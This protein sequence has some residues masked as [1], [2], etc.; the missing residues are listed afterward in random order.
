MSVQQ[1]IL[2]G[3]DGTAKTAAYRPD[4]RIQEALFATNTCLQQLE[5]S[6]APL[7]DSL[8]D[9]HLVFVAYVP[10]SGSTLLT[11]LLARTSQW[12]YVSN[13]QSRFWL[14][15]YVGGLLEQSIAPR[16]YD[17][18]PLESDF[19]LTPNC[20][21]PA[22]FSYFWERWLR[23]TPELDHQ[24][25]PERWQ[26]CDELGLRRELRLIGSLHPGPLLFKKEWLG[27]NACYLLDAFPS[28]KLLH[29]VRDPVDVARSILGA[30]RQVFGHRDCWWG[31]KPASWDRLRSLTWH[32]QIAG[33]IHAILELTNEAADRFPSRCLTLSYET[34][35]AQP[36]TTL[37]QVH[38]WAGLEVSQ[39][40]NIPDQLPHRTRSSV[41]SESQ[42]DAEL[43][44]LMEALLRLNIRPERSTP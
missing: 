7:A 9:P 13:F 29:I 26:A 37:E 2:T 39:R 1:R 17:T 38:A 12:N 36:T 30:R 23:L 24:L 43:S 16:H 8:P 34:L 18:L 25:T 21:S 32:D 33:Q 19:G 3:T 11:Q 10:R 27:M 44:Q 40:S 14:A 35:V 28:A 20:S 42:D 5:D 41:L 6:Y 4:R 22:E 31:A 15:P